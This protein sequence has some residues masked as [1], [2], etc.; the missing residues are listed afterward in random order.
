MVFS[1]PQATNESDK[2]IKTT[3]N[4]NSTSSHIHGREGWGEGGGCK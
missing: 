1:G 2:G 3:L 4:H